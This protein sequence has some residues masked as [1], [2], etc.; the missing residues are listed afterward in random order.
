VH[1]ICWNN[2]LYRDSVNNL[3]IVNNICD[4]ESQWYGTDVQNWRT[5]FCGKT[6]CHFIYIIRDMEIEAVE[7]W[8]CVTHKE[9][10]GIYWIQIN[11]NS[12][13]YRPTLCIT[14]WDRSR[15][16]PYKS[17][18]IISNIFCVL[19]LYGAA[20]G[21]VSLLMQF[22]NISFQFL[23]LQRSMNTANHRRSYSISCST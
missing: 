17:C 8:S 11:Q 5:I 20:L 19:A 21:W 18:G 2:F 1:I 10:I 23:W 14:L 4:F 3:E 13:W 12:L 16:I 15:Q 9:Q 22:A 6:L 7:I